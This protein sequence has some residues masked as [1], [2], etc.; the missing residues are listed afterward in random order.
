MRPFAGKTGRFIVNDVN[1]S[2]FDYIKFVT[3]RKIK[4]QFAD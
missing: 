4:G 1:T 2:Y 3:Y